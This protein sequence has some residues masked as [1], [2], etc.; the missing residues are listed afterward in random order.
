MLI[1]QGA[2]KILFNERIW[3]W[4]EEFLRYMYLSKQISII[5]H[6]KFDWWFFALLVFFFNT[7]C[8][9]INGFDIFVF[10]F[11]CDVLPQLLDLYLKNEK[12]L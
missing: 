8:T 2:E 11:K 3:L 9:D 5:W 7:T 10:A 4:P 6:W 1:C 12:Y